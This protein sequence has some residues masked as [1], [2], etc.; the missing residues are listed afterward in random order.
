MGER[1]GAEQRSLRV[2]RSWV[3]LTVVSLSWIL[4]VLVT[5]PNWGRLSVFEQACI[6]AALLCFAIA[7]IGARRQGLLWFTVIGMLLLAATAVVPSG[8]VV[9]TY[10]QTYLGYVGFI[11]SMLLPRTPGLITALLVPAVTWMILLSGPPNAVLEGFVVA[12]GS[13]QFLRML[14]A[15]LL[16][17]LAWNRLRDLARR[18]DAERDE[19]TQVM[20]DAH[21]EQER[22]ASWR[23][24][25]SRVHA[26]MLNSINAVLE[27]RR[28]DAAQVR[29]L[30]DQGRAAIAKTS[31]TRRP[32]PIGIA[33][34]LPVNAGVVLLSSAI[35][36]A[37]IGGSLYALFIPYPSALTATAAIVIS[38]AGA[39]IAL[40]PVIRWQHIDWRMGSLLVLIPAA[41][42]WVLSTWGHPCGDIGPVAATASLAG[43]A[44]VCIGLWSGPAPFAI[45]IV[46][47]L[48]GA[49]RISQASPVECSIAPNVIVLNVAAFLPVVAVVVLAGAR[50][51]RRALE[52]MEALALE[53][54]AE[55]RLADAQARADEELSD[56]VHRAADVLDT[57][58]RQ[59]AMGA[60]ERTTLRCL[61]S[62]MRVAVMIDVVAA[63]GFSRSTHDL[64]VALADRGIPVDV[65]VISDSGDPRPI[66][67][68]LLHLLIEVTAAVAE[69][70]VR[71]QSVGSPGWD[72]LSVGMRADSVRLARL[73]SEQPRTVDGTTLTVSRG[74]DLEGPGDDGL[75]VI[76][77]ERVIA[78]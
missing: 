21:E 7:V 6:G 40:V 61:A 38:F 32:L 28:V 66:P 69:D 51:H 31:P 30:A 54:E 2:S 35:A 1:R 3:V 67:P 73:V 78:S 62:R 24:A 60:D 55:R 18:V 23:E 14:T 17:W 53:A 10:P 44:I 43:F 19:L 58:G 39:V 57:V 33:P 13:V 15:Q 74:E 68:E 12:G 59:G 41:V 25:A 48:M 9:W 37:M 75:T 22:S 76:T 16:L 26:T 5:G 42:P 56:S 72:F 27:A 20:L 34:R 4:T 47:W 11:L 8:S 36:G 46:I 50:R 64:V 52:A 65:G 29:M 63:Q 71:V 77:V 45:G 49:L 70:A